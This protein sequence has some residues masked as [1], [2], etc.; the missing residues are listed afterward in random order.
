MDLRTFFDAV[1]FAFSAKDFNFSKRCF[2][3]DVPG[4]GVFGHHY[5]FCDIRRK[6][7]NGRFGARADGDIFA[8]MRYAGCRT[9]QN[10]RIECSRKFRRPALAYSRASAGL[11]GSSMGSFEKMATQRLSCSFCEE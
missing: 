5:I 2:D 9:H 8:G 3:E 7:G 4:V 1:E 6:F 10:G 11:A